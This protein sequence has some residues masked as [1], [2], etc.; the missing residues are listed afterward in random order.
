[1]PLAPDDQPALFEFIR[2]ICHQVGAPFPKRIQVDCQVNAS[3][4]FA[5]VPWTLGRPDLVLTIGLPLAAGLSVRQFAGV[6]AHEFGHFAQTG[7]MRLTFIV[8]SINHWLARVAHERDQW[9]ETLEEWAGSGT[10]VVLVTFQ[11]AKA[12]VWIS[13]TILS[14]LMRAG[15]VISSFMLRQMEYDADRYEVSLVGT[16]TFIATSTRMRELNVGAQIGYADLQNAWARRSLPANLPSFL[17]GHCGRLPEALLAQIRQTPSPETSLFDTH[18]SD[19]DRAR[20]AEALARPGIFTGGE[21][22]ASVLFRDFET[23]AAT[24]THHHYIYDLGLNLDAA[25]LMDSA[26]A[27]E[28]TRER[29]RA[30]K[31]L[32]AMFGDALSFQRSIQAPWPP[33]AMTI[34]AATLGLLQARDLMARDRDAAAAVVKRFDDLVHARHLAELARQVL[35]AGFTQIVPDDFRLTSPTGEDIDA[36]DRAARAALTD[37]EPALQRYERLADERI[38]CALALLTNPEAIPPSLR[39]TLLDNAIHAVL[40]LNALGAVWPQMAELHHLLLVSEVIEGNAAKSADQSAA[41]RAMSRLAARQ[42]DLLRRIRAGLGA[43]SSLDTAAAAA[44]TGKLGFPQKRDE[45]PNGITVVG[46]AVAMRFDLVGRLASAV[47]SVE[48]KM[49]GADTIRT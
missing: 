7:G 40:E 10:T 25:T 34:E 16:R 2:A 15:H 18:P 22:P 41:T 33:P 6:L 11:L 32:A 46:A 5:H 27:M 17:V 29:E 43:A 49:S 24:T 30:Q 44:L 9:D 39:T 35:Q 42:H 3:A 4:G 38:G 12:A 23:V 20:A 14:V 45:L 28:A 26:A 1:M 37:L 47:L 31:A 36:A 21:E 48:E 19:A 8:R 13:R